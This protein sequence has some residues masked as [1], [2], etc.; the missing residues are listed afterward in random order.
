MEAVDVPEPT[1]AEGQLLVEVKAVGVS[2]PDLLLSRGEYH[3][4][5]EPPFQIGVDF[6]GVVRSAPGGS[7]LTDGDQVACV[8]PWG[9]A[10]ELVALG[11]DSVFPLPDSVS[12]EAGAALPMTTSPRSSRWRP[13]PGSGRAS[14]SREE[15]TRTR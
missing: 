6:S 12:F 15:V 3:M 7:G 1:V 13:A 8:L 4:K 9:G 11:P 14:H 5:P 2:F 10:A